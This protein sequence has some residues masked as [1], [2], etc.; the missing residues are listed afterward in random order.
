MHVVKA[1]CRRPKR[2]I[3]GPTINEPIGKHIV[4][5]LATEN[6]IKLIKNIHFLPIVK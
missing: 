6:A 2:S 1:I 3:N 4:T 5:K